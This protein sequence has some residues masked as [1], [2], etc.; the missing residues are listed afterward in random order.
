MRSHN[1]VIKEKI[2]AEQARSHAG[3]A[4]MTVDGTMGKTAILLAILT[5]CASFTF[6]TVV[7]GSGLNQVFVFGGAIAGLVLA[8]IIS[9]KPMTA[10]MLAPAY[11]ACQGLL[12]GGISGMY[13]LAYQG[14]VLQAVLLT[15][16]IALAM[17]AIYR[18]RIIRVTQRFRMIVGAGMAGIFFIYMMSFILSFFGASVPFLHST[19][20]IGI[21]ISVVFIVIVSFMLLLDFDMIEKGAQQ[22]APKAMEWYG[23]FALLVTLIWLFIELLRL[24]AKTRD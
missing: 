15:L 12:L 1:P 3:S 4:V 24:L 23:G 9:F 10:P 2:F 20:P 8:L 6:N 19:G 18:F 13:H 17:L 7:S 16:G 21:G 5:V 14:I 22:G 11:A